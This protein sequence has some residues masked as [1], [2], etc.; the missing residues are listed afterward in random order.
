[1]DFNVV[2]RQFG[3]LPVEEYE[4]HFHEDMD[5]TYLWHF[6][7]YTAPE[8][9]YVEANAIH[10]LFWRIKKGF[11]VGNILPLGQLSIVLKI[12]CTTQTIN[13]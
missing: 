12:G 2:S 4:H 8:Y 5:I 1:M 10:N 6:L 7:Q 9:R 3:D 13:N 11:D